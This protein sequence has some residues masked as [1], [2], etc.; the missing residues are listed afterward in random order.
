MD[1]SLD[2][3]TTIPTLDLEQTNTW[4][5]LIIDDVRDNVEVAQSILSFFGATVQVATS[6]EKGFEILDT[7]F[8]NLILMDLNMPRVDGWQALE[9]L[10][11]HDTRCDIPVIAL[12]ALTGTENRDRVYEKGFN[13]YICKPYNARNLI[14]QIKSCLQENK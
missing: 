14:S 7:F 10:Q 5:V 11:A 3:D 2:P 9:Q 6:V 1:I 12:T 8:A 4:N 13:G